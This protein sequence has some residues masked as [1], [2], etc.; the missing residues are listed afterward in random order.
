MSR[1]V[2]VDHIAIAVQDL[3]QA[4]SLW[5]DVLGL[6]AGARETVA[7][8]GV[9]I[10]MMYAGDTRVELVCPLDA[11]SPVAAFLERR[12]PGL[13]HLALAVDDCDQAVH[14]VRA[15]GARVIDA[16]PRSGAH[17]TRIAFLHPSSSGGVLTEL[18]QGGEGPWQRTLAD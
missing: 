11:A 7:D 15:S 9:E 14:Q 5:R 8:Q 18:V 10:Q 2:G 1:V 4:T 12:G 16:E 6:R 13:H 3:D 17:G